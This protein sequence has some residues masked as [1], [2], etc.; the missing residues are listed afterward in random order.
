MTAIKGGEKLKA[1]LAKISANASKAATLSVGFL[2]GS[3]YPNG[4]SLPMVAAIQEFGA[5]KVGIQ[6]RPY[7]RNMVAAKSPEWPAAVGELLKDNDFDAEKTLGQVGEGIK[8]Q[9]QQ[10][11]IDTNEPAL[12]PVTVMLRGMKSN[13]QSL[14]V[15]KTV[16]VEARERVA[17]GLTNYGASEKVLDESGYMISRVG[18]TVK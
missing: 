6:P 13:D 14:V 15:N 5:P 11:I 7:F 12:S 4:T 16:V 17:A 3:T 8:Y 2:E 1:A 18:F 10:S 9:L